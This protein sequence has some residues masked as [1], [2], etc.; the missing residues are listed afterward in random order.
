MPAFR[1]NRLGLFKRIKTPILIAIFLF[2]VI[3]AALFRFDVQVFSHPAETIHV[4]DLINR[5]IHIYAVVSPRARSAGIVI[6][7]PL[8]LFRIKGDA[9][10]RHP[11]FLVIVTRIQ[12]SIVIAEGPARGSSLVDFGRG[13]EERE[14]TRL[15]ESAFLVATAGRL[16][17]ESHVVR[18]NLFHSGGIYPALGRLENSAGHF[19]RIH[20]FDNF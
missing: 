15:Q 14:R 18:E 1:A 2:V 11:V 17:V 7:G 6:T 5:T 4:Q 8:N 10:H 12:D 9:A 16:P 3:A 13:P 20:F 19:S